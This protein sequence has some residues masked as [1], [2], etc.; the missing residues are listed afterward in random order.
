[1]TILPYKLK[2]LL[3]VL[4]ST[5]YEKFIIPSIISYFVCKFV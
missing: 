2:T 3:L 4:L 1:M 5:I